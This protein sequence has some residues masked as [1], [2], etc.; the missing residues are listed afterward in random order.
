MRRIATL[1][2]LSAA[3]I[4]PACTVGPNFHTPETAKVEH[5]TAQEL[6]L[7]LALSTTLPEQWWRLFSS[8]KL[9]GLIAQGLANNLSLH[10]AD[11]RLREVQENLSA[12]VGSVLY[13]AID[14]KGS[15]GRQKISGAPFG[16]PPRIYSVHNASVS[17][18]YGM[19]LFGASKRYLEAM[20]AQ[21]DYARFQREAA[22]ISVAANIATAAISEASLRAQMAVVTQLIL[23]SQA[24]LA[25][26]EQQWKL[27]AVPQRDVLT[28]RSALVEARTAMPSLQQ[29]LQQNRHLLNVLVG[30]MPAN[31]DLPEF[32]LD[33]LK[34]PPQLPLTLP[35]QL[36]HQRPDILAAEALLHQAS[37]NVG[38]AEANRYPHI[39][40]SASLGSESATLGNLFGAGSSIWGL[41]AGLT[42]PLFHGGE[43]KAKKRAAE[44]AY[45]QALA[46]YRD[47]VLQ[48]FR[49]VA[50]ALL[51]LESDQQQLK[52]ADDGAQAAAALLALMQ[53]QY[54]AGATSRIQLLN[55][56]QQYQQTQTTL[57]RAT[58][59][60]LAD[61]AALMHALG[62]GWSRKS[63]STEETPAVA[64]ER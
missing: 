6:K 39:S 23:D 14:A 21:V 29:Q 9:N 22:R 49:D 54:D 26:V 57:A 25:I 18:S 38:V 44:A 1:A 42:Q 63:H 24:Q 34:F 27:G 61:S 8:A 62:G 46:N 58:A 64:S 7:D 60:Q 10:A 37:A 30:K 47:V 12:Q 50:D 19:D 31:V 13:P 59:T 36:A 17:A 40:L 28:R 15:S 11:A 2:A 16:S 32:T 52:L 35:S 3:L 53:K 45:D 5:Y 43:L 51:A 20:E 55:A 4:L 56:H 41:G 33:D 48:A